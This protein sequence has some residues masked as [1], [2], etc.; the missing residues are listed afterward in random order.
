MLALK[1][2]FLSLTFDDIIFVK[3]GVVC[4][5]VAK[6]IGLLRARLR[7]TY[8]IYNNKYTTTMIVVLDLLLLGGRAGLLRGRL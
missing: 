3:W 7:T 1:R 5:I 6:A 2:A 8:I 4:G